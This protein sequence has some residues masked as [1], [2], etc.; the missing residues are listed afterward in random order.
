M[1][2]YS[3]PDLLE[4]NDVTVS[5]NGWITEKATDSLV[6]T[7]YKSTN[8]AGKTIWRAGA[9]DLSS[10]GFTRAEAVQRVLDIHNMVERAR[11]YKLIEAQ[12]L[13]A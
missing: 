6:G 13:R 12:Q 7:V 8:A 4:R 11:C 10:F 1:N 9:H 2:F 5:R 3:Q